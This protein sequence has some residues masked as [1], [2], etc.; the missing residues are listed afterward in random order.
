MPVIMKNGEYRESGDA[1]RISY[2]DDAKKVDLSYYKIG[3]EVIRGD[4]YSSSYKYMKRAFDYYKQSGNLIDV[5]RK[6]YRP[7]TPQWLYLGPGS[8]TM[9]IATDGS[10]KVGSTVLSGAKGTSTF[11]DV[12]YISIT[13][14]GASGR[15][16]NSSKSGGGGGAGGTVFC[17]IDCS[18]LTPPSKLHFTIGSGGAGQT[19]KGNDG[20]NGTASSLQ[21]S[22]GSGSVTNLFAGNAG[23][24]GTSQTGGAGGGCTISNRY[25]LA[26]VLNIAPWYIEINGGKGGNADASGG[27]T[28]W[29]GFGY[30]PESGLNFS[31]SGGG[32]PDGRGGGGGASAWAAGTDGR[33]YKYSTG[34]GKWGSG[35]GGVGWSLTGVDGDSGKG[36][37]GC[38]F[39]FY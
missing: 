14:G 25:V 29:T 38:A 39:I 23:S 18:Y 1:N 11:K 5:A 6:G 2:T 30:R 24:K 12:F 26:E 17:I 33:N 34:A 28:S 31:Q 16:G 9:D 19:S 13:G 3:G 37:D 20:N 32:S 7:G 10:K 27:S 35:S 22:I 21:Y 36:G 15:V 4:T 8:Y